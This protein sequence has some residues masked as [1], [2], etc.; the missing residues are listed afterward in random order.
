[1]PLRVHPHPGDA[2]GKGCGIQ[3]RVRAEYFALHLKYRF[4]AG[5]ETRRTRMCVRRQRRHRLLCRAIW[6]MKFSGN[7]LLWVLL[8]PPH[9]PA[10]YRAGG[11]RRSRAQFFSH[12]SGRRSRYRG[13]RCFFA[14]G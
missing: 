11:D 10:V 4:R 12:F 6:D 1:M 2:G 7:T 3:M 9:S 8:Q 5:I 13:I 14:G